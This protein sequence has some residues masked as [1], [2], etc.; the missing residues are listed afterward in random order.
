MGA[1]AKYYKEIENDI[2]NTQLNLNDKRGIDVNGS[3]SNKKIHSL[4]INEN[5]LTYD[6]NIELN[7]GLDN[8]KDVN[9]ISYKLNH[10]NNDVKNGFINKKSDENIYSKSDYVDDII[11]NSHPRFGTLTRNIRKRRG[12]KVDIRVPIYKDINTNLT[13]ATEDEPYPGSIHM[14]A[15]GF[16]MGSCCLQVTVGTCTLNSTCYLY[17]QLVPLTPIL[18]LLPHLHPIYKGKLTD[19]DNRFSIISQA[20]DDRTDEEKDPNS[21]KYIYKSRYSPAYSYISENIYI[22]DYHNDYPKMPINK[23]YLEKML[24]CG[25]PKRLSEH[26][27]NLLVRDPLVYF[28]KKLKYKIQVIV[29]ILRVSTQPIGIL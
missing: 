15:M 21:S 8:T 4:Y 20:V 3:E 27:C 9:K 12:K 23:E 13:E 2:S 18:L 25:V 1:K 29:L 28:L 22:Q 17:D 24:E 19:Y 14:D 5:E 7:N 26:F 16:G 11:I 10:D 6:G